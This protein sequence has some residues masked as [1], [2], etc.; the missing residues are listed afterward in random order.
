M[1]L[2]KEKTDKE[3]QN[4]V[5][6]ALNNTILQPLRE[7]RAEMK[8]VVWPTR[9]EVIRLTI[10]VIVLSALISAVLFVADSL[11]TWLLLQLQNFVR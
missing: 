1:T 4:P 6:R 11:F 5:V 8:K 2:A 9:Q 3:P 7:S 10:V